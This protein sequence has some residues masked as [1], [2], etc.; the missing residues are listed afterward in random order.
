MTNAP[1]ARPPISGFS[2]GAEL[3]RWYWRKTELVA[4]ARRLGLKT[5]GAK[6]TVLE[7]I[8]HF[9][10]TG[11][12]D[13]LSATSRPIRST[14]DWHG[15]AL[16][17]ATVITDNYRN[18]QNVRRYFKT[19]VGDGFKFT[20]A[21]M[22]WMRE[23]E[24]KTLAD[25][26]A[27]YTALKAEPSKTRIKAHNQFN[28]YTRDFLADNPGASMDDVRQAWARKVQQPSDDGRH[29]YARTDLAL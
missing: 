23:N 4:E 26:C 12:G 20:I 11:E 28:Q 10:D 6:F 2:S 15:A 24:G 16:T 29:V 8:A 3:K 19:A 7:R 18:T 21:L 14:F 1:D 5:G 22:D 9:L 13:V 25:A 27:A 17:D